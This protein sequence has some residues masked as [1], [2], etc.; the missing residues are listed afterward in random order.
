MNHGFIAEP[1]EY[2]QD[3]VFGSNRNLKGRGFR[4]L[5]LEV[6][7]DWE[8]WL[9]PAIFSHQAPTYE[10]N[11]CVAHGTKNI[12][13]LLKRRVHALEDDDSDR[14]LA[15][16][17]GTDPA[18]GNTP[19]AVGDAERHKGFLSEAEWPQATATT[20]DEY[21]APVPLNLVAR[22]EQ[23]AK[24]YAFGYERIDRPTVDALKEA[25]AYSPI[26][27][28]C[29]LLRRSDG[30][31]YK[32]V[33][34]RDGHWV[35]LLRI[36]EQNGETIFRLLDSYPDANGSYIKD[37][38]AFHPEVAMRY[39]LDYERYTLV[40]H[41]LEL[42]KQYYDLV[43]KKAETALT[44]IVVSPDLSPDTPSDRENRPVTNETPTPALTLQ[45]SAM[46]WLGK[47]A[48]PLNLA[49]QE[50]GCAESVC[51][52]IADELIP[53][54]PRDLLSTRDLAE[55]LDGN[56]RFE[57]TLI[58]APGCIIVSPRTATVNGHAGVFLD[59]RR[60]ASND[61]RTG[62]FEANYTLDSWVETFRKKRDLRIQIWKPK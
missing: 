56:V 43:M 29:Y 28:S 55:H 16:I 4:G 19:R 25:L 1:I 60:I 50:L 54:F 17:S 46:R 39:A 44:P 8:K 5:K 61:S 38:I 53:N 40:T 35:V 41:L 15:K 11:A 22:A 20:V 2:G 30:L 58:P 23:N 6:D 12:K 62:K 31:Y 37:A 49:P 32:P 51:S 36:F 7:M 57:R 45:R 10:T 18:R 24:K 33:G 13:E 27:L 9:Y 21:Y 34:E 26:G 42:V 59:T 47:D 14:F 3:L 48:S 52:V